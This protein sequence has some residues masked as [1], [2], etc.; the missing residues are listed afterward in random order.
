MVV[1]GID[2]NRSTKRTI[3]W[4]Q[5]QKGRLRRRKLGELVA[6]IIIRRE[7]SSSDKKLKALFDGERGP[8]FATDEIIVILS[9]WY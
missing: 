4:E 8:A 1:C 3:T 5:W 6:P 9:K 7:T 2:M